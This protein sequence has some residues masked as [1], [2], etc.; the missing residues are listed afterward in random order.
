MIVQGEFGKIIDVVRRKVCFLT[1]YPI[2]WDVD[3]KLRAPRQ[4]VVEGKVRGGKVVTLR[5]TPPSR[6][7]DI[8]VK[9]GLVI[10]KGQ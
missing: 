2:N 9:E 1:V 10:K 5:V 4:T 7:R 3:F 6:R 8:I